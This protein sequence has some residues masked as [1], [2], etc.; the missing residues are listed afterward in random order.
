M[1]YI[2]AEMTEMLSFQSVGADISK[3]LAKVYITG[4]SSGFST[5]A[6]TE[7]ENFRS[8]TCFSPWHAE[9]F[10]TVKRLSC[11]MEK[12]RIILLFSRL[13]H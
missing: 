9:I 12:F 7:N 10:E 5:E 13:K 11:L 4:V 3:I 1:M 6:M 8:E 2:L